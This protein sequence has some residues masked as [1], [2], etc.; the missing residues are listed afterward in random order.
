MG[1]YVLHRLNSTPLWINK[2]VD[3]AELTSL[4]VGPLNEHTSYEFAMQAFNSKGASHLSASVRKTTDQHSECYVTF[5][6]INLYC[7]SFCYEY[8]QFLCNF[9]QFLLVIQPK[10]LAAFCFL[11]GYDDNYICCTD[12]LM[13]V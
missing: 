8:C 4:L 11:H 2:T 3:R 9:G 7:Y 12:T 10:L 6:L 13:M 1:Y 5:F